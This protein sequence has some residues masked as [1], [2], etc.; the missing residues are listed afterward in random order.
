MQAAHHRAGVRREEEYF[1]GKN[2]APNLL[3]L[4][5]EQDEKKAE[6]WFQERQFMQKH[7]HETDQQLLDY[8]AA[9]AD[10]LGH[11]PK[12]EETIGYI[13]LKQR[14]GNWPQILIRAGLKEAKPDRKQMNRERD[15]RNQ[16]L[17]ANYDPRKKKTAPE[18]K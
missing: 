10:K 18:D 1:M 11:I 3:Q 17:R 16:A 7:K 6:R 12:K 14:L 4:P 5:S 13:Y 15:S 8:V 9:L 2:W